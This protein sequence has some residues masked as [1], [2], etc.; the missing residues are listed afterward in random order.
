L[1]DFV[2]AGCEILSSVAARVKFKPR[3]AATKYFICASS[4]CYSFKNATKQIFVPTGTY[5]LDITGNTT[6]PKKN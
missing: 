3:E 2:N 1:I 4:T 5:G 6:I